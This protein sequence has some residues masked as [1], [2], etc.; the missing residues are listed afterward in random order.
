MITPSNIGYKLF[1]LILK[2]IK[3]LTILK[4]GYSK[5]VTLSSFPISYQ[6]TDLKINFVFS[7]HNIILHQM[8]EEGCY[9]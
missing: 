4:I 6:K 1:P 8:K 9:L 5:E 3:V 2:A 7:I